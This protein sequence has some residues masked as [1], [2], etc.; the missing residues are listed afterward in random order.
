[1]SEGFTVGK[2]EYDTLYAAIPLLGSETKIA[3]IHKGNHI[4]TCRNESSARK[5]I[6]KHRKGKSVGELPL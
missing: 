1:M 4:K 6:D 5:F 3:I 2:W